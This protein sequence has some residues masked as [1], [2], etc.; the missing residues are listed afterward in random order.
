MSEE[1]KYPMID[2]IIRE[3]ADRIVSLCDPEEIWLYSR[4]TDLADRI[5]S[6][7]L[8]IVTTT[9]NKAAVET[10]IY[11]QLDCASPYDLTIYTTEE[12]AAAGRNPNSFARS[13]L[14]KGQKLYGK[15]TL[16]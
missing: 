9:S 12:W 7:K 14:T 6:F 13:I 2:E 15:K 3:L 8:C 5:I 4:K 11:L 1:R 10:E 16:E